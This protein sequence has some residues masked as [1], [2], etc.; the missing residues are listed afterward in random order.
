MAYMIIDN[1]QKAVMLFLCAVARSK[2]IKAKQAAAAMECNK[3]V[4]GKAAAK[5]LQLSWG[6]QGGEPP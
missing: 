1:R 5:K 6:L 3:A 4:R 2:A